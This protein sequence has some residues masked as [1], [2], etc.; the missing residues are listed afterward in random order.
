MDPEG[1]L[2]EDWKEKGLRRNMRISF[3]GRHQ[4]KQSEVSGRVGYSLSCWFER[5]VVVSLGCVRY[6]VKAFTGV[7]EQVAT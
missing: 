5:G 1:I 7:V 2:K 3:V 4:L 6:L